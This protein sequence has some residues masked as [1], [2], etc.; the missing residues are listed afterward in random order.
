MASI[1]KLVVLTIFGFFL[2]AVI[3]LLCGGLHALSDFFGK[4][5]FLPPIEYVGHFIILI[6]LSI[7]VGMMTAFFLWRD[8]VLF[9]ALLGA[10]TAHFFFTMKDWEWTIVIQRSSPKKFM[11]GVLIVAI[12]C[13]IFY[14]QRQSTANVIVG[15]FTAF[16]STVQKR[17]YETAYA[18]MSPR[19]RQQVSLNEFINVVTKKSL[20]GLP[21]FSGIC[22]YPISSKWDVSIW[23]DEGRLAD[24]GWDFSD[25]L[26]FTIS[27]PLKNIN[28]EWYLDGEP[29]QGGID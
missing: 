3:L 26:A 18:Y 25:F 16:C 10:L 12:A 13:G 6:I 22:S 29:I 2:G 11:L 19:Y 8:W 5:D 1:R 14:W 28:G 17:D 15:R 9:A 7:P 4:M 21:S 23:G 24:P 27:Y 20:N